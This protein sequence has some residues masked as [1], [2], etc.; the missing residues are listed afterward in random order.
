M[1]DLVVVIDPDRQHGN[2]SFPIRLLVLGFYLDQISAHDG[3]TR[4]QI[5]GTMDGRE[6]GSPPA[7]CF[8]SS[9]K[10]AVGQTEAIS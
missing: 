5:S 2:L 10:M 3:R 7:G 4:N 8:T 6:K 9:N 1:S